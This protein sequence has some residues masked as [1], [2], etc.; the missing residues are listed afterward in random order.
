MVQLGPVVVRKTIAATQEVVWRILID[1]QQRHLW[2]PDTT[3]DALVGGEITEV[4]QEGEHTNLVSRNAHGVI[5]VLIPERTLGFRWRDQADAHTTTVVIMIRPAD[6]DHEHTT[7]TVI[8]SG[9]AHLPDATTLVQAAQ[10]GWQTLFAQLANTVSDSGKTGS[11]QTPEA[12]A[13][14]AA[15]E[16]STDENQYSETTEEAHAGEEEDAAS[17]ADGADN[18]EVHSLE[19]ADETEHVETVKEHLDTDDADGADDSDDT[20][21]ADGADVEV[22]EGELID[23]DHALVTLESDD[24]SGEP[25]VRVSEH[26]AEDDTIEVDQISEWEVIIRGEESK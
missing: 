18:S 3:I 11:D 13:A 21:D 15:D 4:W 17:D 9:F 19:D 24:D 26:F 16:D 12:R 1:A 20:D 23:D 14:E 22:Y 2:W 7:I 6:E 8:E 25:P 5:D 10:E